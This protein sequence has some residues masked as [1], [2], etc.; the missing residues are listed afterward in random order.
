M[1]SFFINTTKGLKLKE[2]NASNVN[3]LKDVLDAYNSYSSIARIGRIVKTNEKFS[4]QPVP[5]DLVR[6][7]ILNLDDS[8]ATLVGDIPVDMLKST[9][10]IHLPFIIKMIHVSF[11]Y[12][13]FPD[14]LK[15]AHASLIFKKIDD[16]DKE[17]Y[18]PAS[19]LPRVR[20]L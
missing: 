13:C 3:T 11:E 17:N 19:I 2:D 16:L 20:D 14:E 15:L 9:V 7:I 10:D 4:F 8:N 5:E 6:E 18:R 12:I 1:G